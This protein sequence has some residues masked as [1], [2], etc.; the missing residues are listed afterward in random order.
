MNPVITL[1]IL[2]CSYM[3]EANNSSSARLIMIVKW[4][5]TG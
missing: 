2:I 3:D 4:V 1:K 5:L